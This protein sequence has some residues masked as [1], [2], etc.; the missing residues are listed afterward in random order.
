MASRSELASRVAE[1]DL[2]ERNGLSFAFDKADHTFR[3][4]RQTR[5]QSPR[6]RKRMGVRGPDNGGGG[7]RASPTRSR[8]LGP[9][10][11]RN[12]LTSNAQG[13][14]RLLLSGEEL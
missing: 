14:V 6:A 10:N 12:I 13:S 11:E 1:L 4:A 8:L 5:E 3:V 9:A 7:A 2:R